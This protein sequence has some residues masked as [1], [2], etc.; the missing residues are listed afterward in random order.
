LAY[1]RPPG[2]TMKK[3]TDLLSLCEANVI[4][5]IYQEFYRNLNTNLTADSDDE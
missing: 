5:N 3:K 2:V 4:P 1:S